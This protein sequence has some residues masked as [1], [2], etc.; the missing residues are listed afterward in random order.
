MD[1]LIRFTENGGFKSNENVKKYFEQ[2]VPNE[3]NNYFY[4][5]NRIN[6]IEKNDILYFSFKGEIVAIGQFTGDTIVEEKRDFNYGYKIKNINFFDKPIEINNKLF[7]GRSVTYIKRDEQ[8]EELKK[9]PYSI[10]KI[11]EIVITSLYVENFTL[12]KK[13]KFDFSKGINIF[14]GE[15]GTGKSH[16]LKL[17]YS[18]IQSNNSTNRNMKSFMG[19]KLKEVFRPTDKVINKLISFQ[20]KRASIEMNLSLYKILFD[21]GENAKHEV[22]IKDNHLKSYNKDVIFIPAKEI[23]SHFKGFIAIYNKREISFDETTYNLAMEL[24]LPLLK[25]QDL[26]TKKNKE[27]EEILEGE[28]IQLNGE[29]YL[30]RFKDKEL[31]VSSMMAEGLRKIGTISYLLKNGALHENSILI[32][33]EPEANLNPKLITV[34]IDLLIFLKNM[35]I[36]IFIASHN[37][38][39]IKYFNLKNKEEYQDIQFISLKKDGESI[40][41][42]TATDI[43]DLE[44]NAIIDEMENIYLES[45]KLFHKGNE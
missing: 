25:N 8:K 19:E 22:D 42:E 32:W 37:Y 14:I 28:I 29:F 10:D 26:I 6:Q 2:K 15:N 1:A 30:R 45:S 24:D 9:V 27:L 43:Y 18:I 4:S 7:A 36:Q 35:D 17:I 5:S 11:E 34:I 23:L 39:M 40:N 44:H 20:E 16:I 21:I 12:F 41:H 33:D 3:Q 38:F 31:V 13:N